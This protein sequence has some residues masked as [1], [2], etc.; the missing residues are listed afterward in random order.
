MAILNVESELWKTH[1]QGT[2]SISGDYNAQ[3]Y[4]D[5]M[6]T[7]ILSSLKQ[8]NNSLQLKFN[9]INQYEEMPYTSYQSYEDDIQTLITKN[10]DFNN[11]ATY[12]YNQVDDS[13]ET[14][15]REQFQRA[16]ELLSGVSNLD[17]YETNDELGIK[18]MRTYTDSETGTTDYAATKYKLKFSDFLPP[19]DNGDIALT[20]GTLERKDTYV[21]AFADLYKKEYDNLQ[22]ALQN[23]GVEFT[24]EEYNNMVLYGSTFNY[25]AD[26]SWKTFV[27][28]V[29]NA[30]II[31]PIITGAVG[32]DPILDRKLTDDERK[33]R[34]TTGVLSGVLTLAT[35]GLA[36]AGLT[37]G[38]LALY[39]LTNIGVGMVGT[40][41]GSLSEQALLELGVSPEVA[42]LLAAGV[43]FAVSYKLGKYNYGK[44]AQVGQ[45]NIYKNI[46]TELTANWEYKP[47][48]EQF[49]KSPEVFL[50]PKYFDPSTGTIHWPG[51]NGDINTNGFLN[52]HS[53]PILLEPGKVIDRYGY[54]YGGSFF[55]EEGNSIAQRAMSPLSDFDTYTTYEILK[56]LPMQSGE[57]APWFNQPGGGIQYTFDPKFITDTFNPSLQIINGKQETIIEWLLRNRY[58]KIN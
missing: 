6:T 5:S 25:K 40:G 21:N 48:L 38:Q 34:V 15:A 7:G 46:Y 2:S 23:Q 30:S 4:G 19:T 58:I 36:P 10:S 20:Y 16:L 1:K 52:G 3:G 47:S 56:P 53:D 29:L 31:Y 32:Y 13:L 42:S 43:S 8:I 35:L 33:S 39:T 26:Y 14:F 45:N 37:A 22:L 44:W 28:D 27:T 11:Y 18:E 51:T 49:K 24:L 57:I 50:N 12:I 54:P 55:G 17:R 9:N 41:A